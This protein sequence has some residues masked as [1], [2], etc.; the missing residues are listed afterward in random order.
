MATY[1]I[2]NVSNDKLD[3]ET[4]TC[5]ACGKE[6]K[7]WNPITILAG[8]HA[9]Q[10]S[11]TSNYLIVSR[12]NDYWRS[13][14]VAADSKVCTDCA[15][16]ADLETLRTADR[17][18]G[19]LACAQAQHPNIRS[20][21]VG[22]EWQSVAGGKLG[23]VIH[24]GAAHPLSRSPDRRYHIRVRDVHGGLWHGT[25]ASGMWA[26]LRRVKPKQSRSAV[27]NLELRD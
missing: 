10:R 16:A 22:Q 6:G 27:R 18:F 8:P 25:G 3:T 2:S 12:D 19:Y 15:M 14:N 20:E 17:M 1:D 4:F 9:G 21:H 24:V 23:T 5:A 7:A 26:S 13:R 11:G